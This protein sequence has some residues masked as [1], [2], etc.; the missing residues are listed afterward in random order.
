MDT[1]V[2]TG[3][4]DLAARVGTVIGES[5]WRLLDQQ[6]VN[7]FA[8]VTGDEQWLHTDPERA[9]TGPFGGTIVHGFFTLAL[10]PAF[11][12]EVFTVTG[13]SARVNYG[14]GAVRFP[15]PLRVGTR[16]RDTIEIIAA[17]PRP[18]AL[19]VSFRH[20]MHAEDAE[21]PVC[22]AETITQFVA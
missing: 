22:V 20:T 17:E 9:A 2:I 14:L 10:A 4:D 18:G 7:D 6:A 8:A 1:V 5:D 11:A 16:V 3:L 12:A 21:R 19:R 13:V 15:A